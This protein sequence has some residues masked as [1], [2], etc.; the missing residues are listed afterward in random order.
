M[1]PR[2]RTGTMRYSRLN[3]GFVQSGWSELWVVYMTLGKVSQPWFRIWM[4]IRIGGFELDAVEHPFKGGP[5]L[6]LL[7]PRTM[8]QFEI[9]MPVDSPTE[10]IAGMIY[11]NFVHNFR[12]DAQQFRSHSGEDTEENL[13][14]FCEAC[15]I[16]RS[17]DATGD[18]P[19]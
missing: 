5:F 4:K 14:T 15:H 12:K 9:A 3:L 13:I 10:Q 8:T 11:V 17:Q 7:H 1:C 18:N 2:S 6:Y 16:A 19:S